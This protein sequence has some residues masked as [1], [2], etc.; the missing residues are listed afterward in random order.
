MSAA[1]GTRQLELDDMQGNLLRGYK[2]R[3]AA[4]RFYRAEH[5]AAGRE[6]LKRLLEH[7]TTEGGR[8]WRS[9][10]KPASTLN[11]AFTFEGLRALEVDAA[12]LSTFPAD[13]REGM[14]APRAQRSLRDTGL[15]APRA[16]G[17]SS[18][19]WAWEDHFEPGRAHMLV[20]IH[21]LDDGALEDAR[22]RLDDLAR[23][24]GVIRLHE[25]LAAALGEAGKERE[26][27]GFTDGFAQP[28]IE[29][30]PGREAKGRSEP[31]L[32]G[33]GIPLPGGGWRPIKPG[34]FVLGYE[35]EDGRIPAAPA[36]PFGANGTFMVYRKLHQDVAR[37][38][39][40][41][42]AMAAIHGA[43]GGEEW[44]AAKI[45]GRWRDGAP[46]VSCPDGPNQEIGDD[47][48]RANDFTYS[49]DLRGYRCPLGAHIRR[50]NPRDALEGGSSRTKRHHLIRRGMPYGRML[51]GEA[52]DGVP[53]G[54]IFIC[55]NASISRQFEVV[56]SWLMDG[57]AFGLGEDSDFLIG[58]N[59]EDEAG[60]WKMT[61]H[62]E[63]PIALS[64]QEPFVITKGGEYLFLPGVRALQALAAQ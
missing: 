64:P 22:G 32:P 17:N 44:I 39:S 49:N 26:H 31:A 21:A 23:P 15:S 5:P 6:F 60:E 41:T 16:A 51:D 48:R 3:C 19:A 56:Q 55:F 40:F 50:S 7:V 11:V 25:D 58:R 12:T 47:T 54:L 13:F 63:P 34:E 4:Y 10:D 46:L 20:V 38:R 52:D 14:A 37:F 61:V 29:G 8:E 62:G 59:E 33:G 2:M 42:Q 35:D 57:N 36:A 27:F 28:A 53:R 30:A 45:V 24:G 43:A 9:G 18:E 1:A